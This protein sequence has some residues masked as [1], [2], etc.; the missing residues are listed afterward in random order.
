MLAY[1]FIVISFIYGDS[2][3][4]FYTLEDFYN[5]DIL[6]VSQISISGKFS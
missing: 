1:Y 5:L 4:F 6:G 3:G 2:Y